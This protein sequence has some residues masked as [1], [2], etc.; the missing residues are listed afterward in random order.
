MVHHIY[1]QEKLYCELLVLLSILFVHIFVHIRE[2][3]HSYQFH[4]EPL[5]NV[6]NF[7][8]TLFHTT[9]LRCNFVLLVIYWSV[10][11][12]MI[13][14]CLIFDAN[15]AILIK[16]KSQIFNNNVIL[17]SS[18]F[19]FYYFSLWQP[20]MCFEY[21]PQYSGYSRGVS[22]V[23]KTTQTIKRSIWLLPRGKLGA[24]FWISAAALL[25]DGFWAWYAYVVQYFIVSYVEFKNTVVIQ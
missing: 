10:G 23:F 18:H 3:D 4:V 21:I 6:S 25:L 16:F 2:C 19:Y 13:S 5:H 20:F 12:L 9:I 11:D 24:Y 15:S 22:T 7:Q 14:S 1:V 8:T 17:F